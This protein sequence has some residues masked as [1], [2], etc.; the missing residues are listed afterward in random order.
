MASGCRRG[1]S[2]NPYLATVGAARRRARLFGCR[3]ES[4][5]A[6]AAGAG[7]R[8]D[9]SQCAAW[10]PHVASSA[11][12]SS[13]RRRCGR[14]GSA[15]RS[16]LR[17][18]TR[19]SP[20]ASP[21]ASAI[22]FRLRRG[23]LRILVGCGAAGG[24]AGAF[25]APLAGAFYGFELIIGSYS[26]NSLAPVGVAALIGYLVAHALGTGRARRRRSRE[27]DDRGARSG[28]RRDARPVG[29]GARALF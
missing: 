1:C 23:D 16:A 28:A 8:S 14:A 19:N 5:P 9:R 18:A 3:A 12:S 24:I 22:A 13:R 2:L 21:R 6:L 4:H 11:A 25:G 7:N 29:G 26:P 20:A 27:D 10:R 15:P 17:P